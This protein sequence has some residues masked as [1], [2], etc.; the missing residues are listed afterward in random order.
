MAT[1]ILREQLATF[2]V[3]LKT[4]R[5]ERRWTLDDLAQ[6][7]GFS[8]GYLSRLESGDRQASIASILT[9]ARLFGTSVA[10]LFEGEQAESISIVRR[11]ATPSYDVDGLT[12][13]P[14]SGQSWPFQL[15]P[16]RV[17]VSPTREGD[18]HRHHDGE[19]WIFVLSGELSLS[20]GGET[21]DLDAGDA[22]HF[23]ARLPHRLTARSGMEAEVLL[24]AAPGPTGPFARPTPARP[25]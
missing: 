13:W 9:L 1:D 17:V 6:R 21:H 8:K 10:A 24:V 19:E 15:Q 7:S 4:L 11:D 12:C 22:A 23:D 5:H 18:E 25:F 14:L 16:V 20:I 2:G 3:R